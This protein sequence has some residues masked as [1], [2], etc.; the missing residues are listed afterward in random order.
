M[1]AYVKLWKVCQDFG[2]GLQQVN[3]A[4]DNLE[5]F[6]AAWAAEHSAEQVGRLGHRSNSYEVLGKHDTAPVPRA[7]IGV[8]VASGTAGAVSISADTLDPVVQ[9][10]QRSAAGTWFVT[11]AAPYTT[12][13]SDP[14]PSAT[15]NAVTRF[16][17]S[18]PGGVTG[19]N[20]FTVITYQLTGGAFVGTDY[21]WYAAVYTYDTTAATVITAAPLRRSLP[22]WSPRTRHFHPGRGRR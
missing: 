4:R 1:A 15:S 12:F 7:M 16:T 19:A 17:T 22:P 5:T 13:F 10:I 9:S 8:S 2:L 14:V 18:Q 11:M 3:Q 6:L 21:D 20:G